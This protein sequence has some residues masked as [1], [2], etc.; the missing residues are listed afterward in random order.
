MR[1]GDGVLPGVTIGP[2]INEAA[3]AKVAAHVEDAL[4]RGARVAASAPVAGDPKRFAAPIVLTG[5]TREMRLANEETF[6]PVAPIF[7]FHSEDEAIEIANST[8]FGLA[9]YFYTENLK[10]SFRVAEKL[11]FGMVGL[12]TGSVSMEVAPFGGVKQSGL[13]REGGPT[14]IEEYLELKS[15]HIDNLKA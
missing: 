2:L 14:G 3:I 5:A 8:P 6:G 12:N 13:G 10:R 11:E 15:F 7:R 4:A 1:V 9:S